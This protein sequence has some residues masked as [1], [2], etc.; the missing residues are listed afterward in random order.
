MKLDR[1]SES[2]FSPVL[3]PNTKNLSK[4]FKSI[5]NGDEHTIVVVPSLSLN[6]DSIKGIV[7]IIHYESRALWEILKASTPN[8]RIVF[9]TSVDIKSEAFN[10]F[11]RLLPNPMEAKARIEFISVNDS[12]LD[13]CLTKK[14][15]N[16]E[17]VIKKI[18][19]AIKT[20]LAYLNV[21]ISSADE[22]S[23]ANK[24]DI[25]V[26]GHDS[27]LNYYLTKS[28]N[29]KVFKN[30]NVPFTPSIE[31]IQTEVELVE[32]IIAL[33][34]KYTYAKR[35]M[36]KLDY[37]V[38]GI[39]NAILKPNLNRNQFFKLNPEEQRQRVK[40]WLTSMTFQCDEITW[41]VYRA[42]IPKGC[43]VEVFIE[44]ELKTSPSAQAR[45]LPDG[46][47][48]ILSTHEQ[49]LDEKGLTFLGSVFPARKNFKFILQ[50]NTKRIGEELAKL[51]FI[52]PFSIDFLI[53]DDGHS[54]RVFV[55]EIN[56]RQGGTTHPYQTTK[57][58]TG[59]RYCQETGALI[60]K[61]GEKF[62]YRS[63][64]NV[65]NT[66]LKGTKLDQFLKY[67]ETN[68]LLFNR[69]TGEGVVFH[70]LGALPSDGKVGYT[71]IAK[72]STKIHEQSNK[73][74]ELINSYA[75]THHKE[76]PAFHK[77]LA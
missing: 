24:L 15:L 19:A 22:H 42:D 40:S 18:K 21:F 69:E 32:A 47:V 12:N 75:L 2:K 52:G 61:D 8:T 63:N 71:S 62:Y 36:V 39:G 17:A 41:G 49:I 1:M 10:H 6:D 5:D 7:G 28:G 59:S 65:I 51:G 31:D 64:D 73:A 25:P 77:T 55:I 70:L 34:K 11:L 43:I 9:V 35:F 57:L 58:L 37:G 46:E 67:M 68:N 27:S 29:K 76:L 72:N 38:S 44:G 20:E 54:Q 53:T 13:S 48:E 33:W 45:I 66:N 4:I 3:F 26:F 14:I 74:L 56:I 23:L 16:N 60:N 30:A 50:E